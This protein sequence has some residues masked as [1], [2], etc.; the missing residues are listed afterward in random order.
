MKTSPKSSFFTFCNFG[1]Q[2]HVLSYIAKSQLCFLCF[3]LSTVITSKHLVNAI[4]NIFLMKIMNIL[5]CC[6]DNLLSI[7]FIHVKYN[8][9][10]KIAITTFGKINTLFQQTYTHNTMNN[11]SIIHFESKNPKL[12]KCGQLMIIQKHKTKCFFCVC[13]FRVFVAFLFVWIAKK[14]QQKRCNMN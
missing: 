13:S 14:N 8:L 10:W 11:S 7:A 12:I 3:Y 1:A 6:I 5:R 2:S 4:Y 9:N